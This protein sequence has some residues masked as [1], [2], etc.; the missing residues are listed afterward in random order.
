[1]SKNNKA[2]FFI[3]STFGGGA[4]SVSL[5][6]AKGLNNKNIKS[7]FITLFH[8]SIHNKPSYIK[9]YCLNIKRPTNNLSSACLMKKI[10]KILS[11]N[12]IW[13]DFLKKYNN[14]DFKLIT[15]HLPLS[16]HVAMCSPYADKTIYVMHTTQQIIHPLFRNLHA[17][18]NYNKY[19][20]KKISCVSKGIRKE[21]INLYEFDSNLTKAIYNPI[22]HKKNNERINKLHNKPYILMIGRL[23][24]LK[25]QNLAIDIYWHSNLKTKIDLIILGD[26]PNK[27]KLQ[28]HINK[29]KLNNNIILKGYVKNTYEWLQNAILLLS[30]SNHEGLPMNI[31]EALSQNTPVIARDCD[32]GPSEILTG[33][34]SKFLIAKNANCEEYI[35]KINNILNN[36]YPKINPNILKPFD[37][38]TIIK[39]YLDFYNND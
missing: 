12:N 37:I 11:T 30:T 24:N 34:L 22:T 25:N 23:C 13:L 15:S 16:H 31:L 17:K 7:I 26:G 19:E 33:K 6:L 27:Q 9:E 5:N 14:T 36:G 28:R 29:L 1:M 8:N 10:P 35:I 4:E 3:N 18:F 20:N 2:L 38:D 32:F 39:Q 21:L